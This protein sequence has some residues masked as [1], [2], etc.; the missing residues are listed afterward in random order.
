MRSCFNFLLV[1]LHMVSATPE[2]FD[3]STM[4]YAYGEKTTSKILMV[5]TIVN[6]IF[7]CGVL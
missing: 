5:M 2:I 6:L 3:Y 1:V 4:Y 7:R